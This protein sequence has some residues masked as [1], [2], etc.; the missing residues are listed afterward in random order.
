MTTKGYITVKVIGSQALVN[1]NG[2][3]IRLDLS[4]GRPIAFEVDQQAIDTL[5]R[6][7]TTAETLLKRMQKPGNA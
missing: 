4:P 5:R 2:V 6:E 3:A 1:P 7:L